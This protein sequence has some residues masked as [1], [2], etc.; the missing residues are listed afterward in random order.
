MLASCPCATTSR[1]AHRA[2]SSP[3]LPRPLP[4]RWRPHCM[5]SRSPSTSRRPARSRPRR[6]WP[7]RRRRRTLSEAVLLL[8][9][10]TATIHAPG[11]W[12]WLRLLLPSATTA[13]NGGC[14]LFFLTEAGAGTWE[15]KAGYTGCA[16]YPHMT[17]LPKW[18]GMQEYVGS[19]RCPTQRVSQVAHAVCILSLN[20]CPLFLNMPLYIFFVCPVLLIAW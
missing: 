17:R 11:R 3:S 15:G 10:L 7:H 18:A 1:R 14:D 5:L 2:T 16:G 12:G 4:W 9:L 13:T 6:H 8:L 20:P 19:R